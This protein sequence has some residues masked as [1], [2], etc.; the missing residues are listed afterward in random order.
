MR[1]TM[2]SVTILLLAISAALFGGKAVAAGYPER[3][4]E[5]IVP[6]GPGWWRRSTRAP[7]Q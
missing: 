7:R 1:S 4:I 3:P 2:R 6:V 5:L